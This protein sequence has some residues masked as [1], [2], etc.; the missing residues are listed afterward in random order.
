M[1]QNVDDLRQQRVSEPRVG[2]A[3]LADAFGIEG[4]R[5][6]EP[7]GD[8]I[9]AGLIGRYEARPARQIAFA[10]LGDDHRPPPRRVYLQPD[11]PLPDQVEVLDGVAGVEEVFPLG[12]LNVGGTPGEGV[13]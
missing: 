11:S 5:P 2:F 10:D 13:A 3:L 1:D 4:R 12:E 7:V 6:D 9:K 8:G